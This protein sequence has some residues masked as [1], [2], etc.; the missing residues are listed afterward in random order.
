VFLLRIIKS[1][2]DSQST[3]LELSSSAKILASQSFNFYFVVPAQ[4]REDIR[5]YLE[6]YLLNAFDPAPAIAARIE[7][8]ISQ[9]GVQLF[10]HLFRA[11]KGTEEVWS[12]IR[13]NLPSTRI[14]IA[15]DVET[16]AHIPW[17]LI[18][19]PA[20]NASLSLSVHSFVR[21]HHDVKSKPTSANEGPVRILLV[22]SRPSGI[23]D[24][25][26]RSVATRLIRVLAQRH[27][28][29]L[30]V[31]R[32]PTFERFAQVLRA[33]HSEGRP[34]GVVH[35]DGHGVI[36]S[37]SGG[38][39]SA[40]VLSGAVPIGIRPGTHGYLLFE[41]PKHIDA[42][43]P[44]G[45]P[46][47]SSL[48]RETDTPVLLLNACR[49]AYA[50]SPQQPVKADSDESHVQT[51]AF[52]SLAQ[53][54]VDGG[55]SGV[56]AMRYKIHVATA[57]QFIAELY[58]SL[59]VGLS[60]GE[61][62]TRG[63]MDLAE[64]PIRDVAQNSLPLQDWQ[65]PVVYESS[66]I[67]F[68]VSMKRQIRGR[69]EKKTNSKG[70]GHPSSSAPAFVGRDETILLLDRAFDD[71]NTVLL[72]GN[73]GAGKTSAA[74]EFANWYATTL[75]ISGPVLFTSFDGY[76]T[77]ERLLDQT[78]QAFAGDLA[79]KKK[80]WLALTD[81]QRRTLMLE[82]MN[83]TSCL[84]IWDGVETI[85]GFPTAAH[86]SW[87]AKEQEALLE[88][89]NDI[90]KTKARILLTSRR[91][92]EQLLGSTATVI[93]IRPMAMDDC[94]EFAKEIA[95]KFG[96]QLTDLEDWRPLLKYAQ[97][98]PLTV[99]CVI[100][101]ALRDGIKTKLQIDQY[102]TGLKSGE[103]K[104]DEGSADG[105]SR[106]LFASLNYGFEHTFSQDE[107]KVLALLHLF[108]DYV[109]GILFTTMGKAPK[110]WHLAEFD[111]V[112]EKQI[113][114]ILM[115]ASEV[116]LLTHRAEAHFEM[117]PALP[118]FFRNLHD[119][120]YGS[121]RATPS[122]AEPTRSERAFVETLSQLGLHFLQIYEQGGR[123]VIESLRD[124]EPNFWNAYRI[125]QKHGWWDPVPGLIQG[126][127][128][129]YQHTGRYAEWLR[130]LSEVSPLFID[131]KTNK[132]LE[133]RE[134]YW[135]LIMDYHVRLAMEARDWPKAER[136]VRLILESDRRQAE[137][138]TKPASR[139]IKPEEEIYV[140]NLATSLGRIGDILRDQ[141]KTQCLTFYEEAIGLYRRIGDANGEASR[142]FNL[143][144][145][146]KN[147]PAIRDL[148]RSETWYQKSLSLRLDSDYLA[149]SQCLG[150]LGSIELE[151]ADKAVGQAKQSH[152]EAAT[153]Y[154]KQALS[155]TPEDA[156]ADLGIVHSQLGNAY[157][158]FFDTHDLALEHWYKGIKFAEAIGDV[159]R[160]AGIRNNVASILHHRGQHADAREY[161]Q[162]ALTSL[163]QAGINAPQLRT[164]LNSVLKI[165]ERELHRP[166]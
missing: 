71:H 147:L 33:A 70:D 106:S 120:Y 85:K 136:L 93:H 73:A 63:R 125:A 148:D 47:I 5:W 89:L 55:V 134:K 116:G 87:T 41:T 111:S 113:A 137:Q 166:N 165:I 122:S 117:H 90:R 97:G 7:Q 56:V 157:G 37:S 84:W 152:A 53:E 135:G 159:L 35:F 123:R 54:L 126:L 66:P 58:A 156:V 61:A 32:P 163:D 100:G 128:G 20:T 14:E 72:Y 30:D 118:W 18:R 68:G 149:R 139:K 114:D 151:R 158:Y 19:D 34:Y 109:N 29:Q 12:E 69:T 138:I 13:E 83:Q 94:L 27:D 119:K 102:L 50:E 46:E 91:E 21:V 2:S 8:R 43:D 142:A 10:E 11:N 79:K 25:P 164:S 150:Q 42:A 39:S 75:G 86:S 146:Y 82:L 127:F 62:V 124:E 17:E 28:F 161:I 77:A 112:S 48:L 92:E 74:K 31:L 49:S 160:A 95:A 76:I 131:S 154:Y 44:I 88:L 115:R 78:E 60:L 153:K 108:Q 51:S 143:G 98:N 99:K 145:A 130:L 103:A 57:A 23:D 144:H 15:T 59:S 65:V 96:R 155:E 101:Q 36:L 40:Q 9:I 22:I 105:R 104:L 6:D 141:R 1:S 67:A 81:H 121:A 133:G 4:D 64:S 52:A 132:S 80:S 162:S 26:Y 24:I 129:L 45:G 140:R 110:P 107:Q 3:K 16:S 38:E